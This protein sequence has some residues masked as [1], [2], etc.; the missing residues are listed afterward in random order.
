MGQR[1]NIYRQGMAGMLLAML[2]TLMLPHAAQAQTTPP[3]APAAP[4]AQPN[5]EVCTSFGSRQSFLGGDPSA[6]E[7][8]AGGNQLLS[9]VYLYITN[10]VGAATQKLYEAFTQNAG[11]QKA[12]YA[13]LVLMVLIFGVGFTMGVIQPSFG[14]VLIRLVK[15]GLVVSLVSS[16][17][18]A[19]FNMYVVTFFNQGTDDLIV[20]VTQIGT[21][22]QAPPNSTPF[23]Q[24]DKIAEF[25]IH[26]DS[27]IMAMGM[28]GTG[29]PFGLFMGGLSVITLMMFVKVL[30]KALQ[31]Y[32]ISYVAR[33]LLLGLG[34][35][36]IV[37]LLFDKTKQLFQSWVNALVSLSLQPILLF[38]F[39][40][41][42]IVLIESAARDMLSTELCW[43]EFK[44]QEGTPNKMSFW[45]LT[46]PKTGQPIASEM[47]WKGSMDC[48]ISGEGNCPEFPVS[49]IDTLTFLMLVYLASRFA[50][51]T[52]RI[53][54]ELSNSYISLDPGARL[55]QFG[56]KSN[57]S[58]LGNLGGSNTKSKSPV[59]TR[60]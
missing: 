10:V 1:M 17:G 54:S 35:I 23:Y 15:F 6:S 8:S 59:G 24:L 37:F 7:G 25:V 33:S 50:E 47:T 60:G 14:Q 11:Y 2:V 4:T 49:I 57:S 45:R 39:L 58:I 56:N 19:F 55:E 30:V 28:V 43:G 21:G 40:S 22:V 41:F 29:G 5:S 51:I 42:F 20:A 26:P 31:I 12:V 9:E 16:T 13:S 3:V 52:E 53:A 27:I 48:I 44:S 18:W 32:A 36:F 38:T 46:D 34:P